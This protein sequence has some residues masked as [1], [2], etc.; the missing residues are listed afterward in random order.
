MEKYIRFKNN[1]D[2]WYKEMKDAGLTKEEMRYVEPYFKNSYGVP[3]SQEQLMKMLMDESICHFSLADANAARK[4]VGKKQMSKIPALKE[5][6]LTQASSPALGRYIWSC[7]VGPQMGY[8]FSIIHALAYSFIG[9]QTAYLATKWNPIYW[10]TACLVVNSG[11]LEENSNEELDDDYEDLGDK[12]KKV[13]STDY[14]KVAKAI[15]DITSRGINVSLAN[16]N[17]SE[18]GFTPDVKNNRIL[19]GLKA[20]S[21]ISA[22]VVEKIKAGRPYIGLKDFMARCPLTKTA[23][24]NLIKAGAFDEV[25]KVLG[26]RRMIMAYYILQVSEPKKKVNLINWS[27]LVQHGLVPE[28]LTMQIRVYNF[29]KYLKANCKVGQY[30][31]F[32][33]ICMDFIE[34]FMPDI[35]NQVSQINGAFCMLQ[36][37]WDKIYQSYMDAAREWL[38]E[39]QKDV[40][41]AYNSSLFKET[42]E[43]YAS[44]TE[45]HWEMESLC[46]YHGDHELKDIDMNKYNLSNFCDLESCEVDYFFQRK[47]VQIPIYKLYRI[48]GTVIAKNDN[49]HIVTLLTTTGVVNVKFTREYYSMFKKQISQVQE[50]G[51]KKVL[52]KSWFKRG[53]MLMVTGFKRDDQFVAK[54]YTNTTTHQLY[55]IVEVVGD[56]MKLQHERA[57]TNVILEDE[58]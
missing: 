34:K 25:E 23:M 21:N 2:L 37:E 26:S 42:W 45:S 17:T 3:P 14:A 30:F 28:Y 35:L 4:I 52:E 41:M 29:T 9:Y 31:Q 56:E 47:G 6:V 8:S 27:G 11:S 13:K 20:L 15:G 33:Q 16:I 19:Y 32:N 5:Q 51:T 40:L 44:G 46:F 10:D 58:E 48:I 38:K 53:T 57:T 43:K 7:G 49:T 55:K 18:L 50:N 22:E 36:T 1:L 12:K 39:N 54:T 24:V